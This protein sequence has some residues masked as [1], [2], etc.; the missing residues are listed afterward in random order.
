MQSSRIALHEC[1]TTTPRMRAPRFGTQTTSCPGWR[2]RGRLTDSSPTCAADPTRP[3]VRASPLRTISRT[4]KLDIWTQPRSPSGAGEV[5][6]G[7]G[8]QPQPVRH[9]E[10]TSYDS[11]TY[12]TS[13][14]V[15]VHLPVAAG[16]LQGQPQ[17]EQDEFDP[18]PP[19]RHRP[20]EEQPYAPDDVQPLREAQASDER[21][22][23]TV[24][25][26]HPRTIS[27]KSSRRATYPDPATTPNQTCPETRT[28]AR[29]G[30]VRQEVR[31]SCRTQGWSSS[32]PRSRGT[33]PEPGWAEGSC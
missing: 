17:H 15:P 26:S 22:D 11:P 25:V 30:G 13:R 6:E 5:T 3:S 21:E 16:H 31:C 23:E 27:Q 12:A 28:R 24:G 18:H 20:T 4:D 2:Y 7:L 19:R 10:P 29:P 9:P 1:H 8:P 14:R 33:V 32:P